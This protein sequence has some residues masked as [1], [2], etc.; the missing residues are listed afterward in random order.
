MSSGSQRILKIFQGAGITLTSAFSC[1]SVGVLASHARRRR[2]LLEKARAA[3]RT[4]GNCHSAA[5]AT[6]PAA[7]LRS[8]WSHTLGT[9]K[10]DFHPAKYVTLAPNGAGLLAP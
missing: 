4:R 3:V 2:S 10:S 1:R 7:W 5:Y 8:R 9:Q 6:L